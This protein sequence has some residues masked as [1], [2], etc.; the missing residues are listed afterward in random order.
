MVYTLFTMTKNQTKSLV[1][2][3]Y[4][5]GTLRKVARSH[6]QN[7][8]TNDLSDNIAS[9]TFRVSIIGYFLAE[10]EKANIQK[11]LL[12]CLFHDVPE[13]RSGDQNWVHKRYV[14]VFEKQI[15]H[16]QLSPLPFFRN[17][18]NFITEYV[19]RETKESLIAKDADLL[20]Q[21]LLL[22]EYALQGNKEAQVWLKGKDTNKNA[23][24]LMLK[25]KSA[26]KLGKLLLNSN[27][28]DWWNNLS[29]SVRN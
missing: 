4:E 13:S 18:F 16:D 7:L 1:N 25:T 27:P 6:R 28:S 19:K 21:I 20:D 17:I 2:F 29:T 23:Q 14:K 9:H 15:L 3:F 11:V 12:M 26:K 10:L 8:L 22:K 5:L 24:Y